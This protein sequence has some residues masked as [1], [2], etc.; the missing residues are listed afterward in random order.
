MALRDSLLPEFDHEMGTTRRLLE[1][2]PTDYAWK[3]H[4]KSMS[5]GGLATHVANL[6]QWTNFTLE[7][8]ALDLDGPMPR[9]QEA[10]SPEELLSTFDRNVTAARAAIAAAGD[11]E[12]MAHWTLRRGSREL[13]TLPKVAV[14][15]SFVV[16]HMIHHRG[17]LSVYLRLKDVPVPSIYG[18]SADEGAF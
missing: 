17:Q 2:V 9:V 15:R 11:G 8:N 5:L 16:N 13:F 12:L 18:P 10:T 6:P 1:R 7:H 14:L 4:P 3:P